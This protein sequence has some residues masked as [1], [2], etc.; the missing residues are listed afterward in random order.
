M[1]EVHSICDFLSNH[2]N[3]C[4]PLQQAYIYPESDGIDEISNLISKAVAENLVLMAYET[5]TNTLVG[6]LIGLSIKSKPEACVE[7]AN[8]STTNQGFIDIENIL[9]YICAKAN[10]CERFNVEECFK[11]EIVAVHQRYRKQKIAKALF[12]SAIDLATSRKFKLVCSDC[13]SVYASIIAESFGMEC[14][15][16]VSYDEYNDHIGKCLF[17]PITPHMEIKTFIK[18]I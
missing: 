1:S 3:H 16:T 6:V 10:V 11:I 8:D 7:A 12:K 18:K 9:N 14:V 2:F 15:S 13:V 17:V 5:V 4:N